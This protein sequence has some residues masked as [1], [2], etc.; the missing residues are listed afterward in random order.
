MLGIHEFFKRIQNLHS[1]EV[2]VR[3]VI[4]ES[5]KKYT[6][7]GLELKDINFQESTIVLKNTNQTFKSV[8]FTKK[9]QIL[10]DINEKQTIRKVTDI[11]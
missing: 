3:T 4:Q 5:L 7:I 1:K 8:V 11:R 10:N 2:F 9:N 6:N